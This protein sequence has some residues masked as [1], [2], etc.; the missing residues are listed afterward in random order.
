MCFQ[1]VFPPLVHSE[2]NEK[3][4]QLSPHFH[5]PSQPRKRRKV[6]SSRW[7]EKPITPRGH[8]QV[9]LLF[10]SIFPLPAAFFK[11]SPLQLFLF[12]SFRTAAVNMRSTPDTNQPP[13][14][15]TG[16]TKQENKYRQE[17][18]RAEREGLCAGLAGRLSGWTLPETT[19]TERW[20][21]WDE[22]RPF[23]RPGQKPFETLN[24][25]SDWIPM[26]PTDRSGNK[27][28]L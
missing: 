1:S 23:Y 19:E 7:K 9:T 18:R 6:S 3:D 4:R 22:V 15:I 27:R 2:F 21:R 14:I 16:A 12:S 26:G 24:S 17:E 25:A 8:R 28:E 20:Q 11:M 10:S 13:L 5:F